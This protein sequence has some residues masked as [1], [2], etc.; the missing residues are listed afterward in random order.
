M[1]K[2]I[3]RLFTFICSLILLSAL[4]IS[5]S[6]Q[7]AEVSFNEGHLIVFKPGG[8]TATDLF[9][10]FK[11][12]MPGDIRIENIT[13]INK[14]DDYEKIKVY[15]QA[16]IHDEEANPLSEE[17]K[18]V[19][20]NDARRGERSELEYMNDFLKELHLTI[21]Q[22][23]RVIY[24]GQANELDGLENPVYL[25][26]YHQE[27]STLLKAE[28]TVPL[29]MGNDYMNRIGEFDLLFKFEGIDKIPA[30]GDI[31]NFTPWVSVLS[32]SLVGV[33]FLAFIFLKKKHQ[34]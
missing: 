9:D 26:E 12:L 31:R 7:D 33:A 3:K 23:D 8:Y 20:T 2:R 29:E 24:E 30:T 18:T 16:L 4:F 32:L 10:N 5:V 14:T 13:V 22:G 15:I 17:V 1:N 19:L 21:K 6:A 25:G 27:E 11:G 34:D 28:L